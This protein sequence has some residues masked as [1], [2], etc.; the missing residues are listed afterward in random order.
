MCNVFRTGRL[1]PAAKYF[2]RIYKVGI[3]RAGGKIIKRGKI[4]SVII[5]TAGV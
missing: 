2:L 3:H 1:G 5:I 4:N